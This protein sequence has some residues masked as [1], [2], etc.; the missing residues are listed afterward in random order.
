[1]VG[2]GLH[3]V[4]VSRQTRQDCV[5]VRFAPS[6]V[7]THTTLGGYVLLGVCLL[8]INLDCWVLAQE[9]TPM[10]AF[11]VTAVNCCR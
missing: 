6:H 11:L 4:D 3:A 9:Y 8:V 5:T 2:L 7:Y 10:S 1:M